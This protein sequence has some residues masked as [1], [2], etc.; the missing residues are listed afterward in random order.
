MTP[1]DLQRILEDHETYWG[2]RR[3]ELL[4]YKAA[5]EM[6]FWDESPLN[7]DSTQIRIQ[8]NDGYGYIE[9][10]Q[11]SLFAKNPAVVVKLGVMGKGDKKKSEEIINAFLLQSRSE[12]ENAS[13]MALI[14]PNSFL[15]LTPTKRDSIYERVVPVAVPPWQIIVD[16]DASRWDL[17]RYV[18][19]VYWM[20]VPEAEDKF[21]GNFAEIGERMK[22]FFD[23]SG[24]DSSFGYAKPLGVN[25][26]EPES[27]MFKYVKIVEMY[28]LMEDKLYWW[29]PE[30]GDAWLD[31]AEF[32]P[33]QDYEETP[34]PP[35][36]PF[37]YNRIP[38]KPMIGYSAIKRVYDQLYEMNIIRSFQANAV[39]KA[40]RQWL[41][42]K[43]ALTDDEMSRI[44]SGIDGLFVEVETDE[45]LDAIIRPVPH[46][47][48]PLEVTRYMQEIQSDK[49][50]G[51]VTA[52]FTRGEV[53]KA[54][55]TEVAALAAYTTSEIGRMARERDA[56]IELMGRIYLMMLAVFIGEEKQPTLAILDGKAATV[57]PDDINGDFQVFAAD[58]AST[59]IS[60]AIK[61]QRLL[62]NIQILQ[63]L[64]VPNNKLLKEIVRTLGLPEDFMEDMPVQ[65]PGVGVPGAASPEPSGPMQAQEA[66][67]NPS[68]G[69]VSDMI[70]GGGVG[71][72]Q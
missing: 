49:D 47:N 70:L 2:D 21:G 44:T 15:K 55:A 30:R 9:S 26:S 46:E 5:Y 61:N 23:E 22:D 8:T 35:I 36:I 64:G 60:E 65:Q 24:T 31:S 6:D 32:I 14:Y 18:G 37:Y 1:A 68:P 58:Q 27:P 69:N 29:C 57:K 41:V 25:Q 19:H 3:Q 62:S 4:R 48:L 11:A 51:S 50:K 67:S 56:A 13:R 10:F 42:K 45:S 72:T 54:T 17:Q 38:D 40:S 59:P 7:G 71:F 43:G 20:T 66:I 63:A 16:T 12:I 33:V 52:P 39:R 34:Y 53:T 28:D